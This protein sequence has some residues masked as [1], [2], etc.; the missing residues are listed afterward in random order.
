MRR[1]MSYDPHNDPIVEERELL[2]LRLEQA[3]LT[4]EI[5]RSRNTALSLVLG[6]MCLLIL[7]VALNR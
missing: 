1:R 7:G 5:L 4:V 2:R 6:V 3:L